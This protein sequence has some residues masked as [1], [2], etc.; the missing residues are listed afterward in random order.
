MDTLSALAQPPSTPSQPPRISAFESSSSSSGYRITPIFLLI[1]LIFYFSPPDL[2]WRLPFLS[3][4]AHRRKALQCEGTFQYSAGFSS[5]LINV[6]HGNL[7]VALNRI[8]SKLWSADSKDKISICFQ[9]I[10]FTFLV[11]L[12]PCITTAESTRLSK[13]YVL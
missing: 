6:M 5:A 13:N 12:T 4:L 3:V 7:E 2:R 1:L 11:N 9:C 8:F 10:Y